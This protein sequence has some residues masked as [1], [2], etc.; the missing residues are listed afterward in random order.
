MPRRSPPARATSP[1]IAR[2][3][4]ALRSH[5]ARPSTPNGAGFRTRPLQYDESGFPIKPPTAAKF[6]ERVR[7]MLFTG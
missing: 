3:H 5:N 2:F 4:Q 7:R 1:D 6:A